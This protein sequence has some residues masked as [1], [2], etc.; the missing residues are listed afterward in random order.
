MCKRSL[1]TAEPIMPKEQVTQ[2]VHLGSND[3]L[4]NG[5]MCGLGLLIRTLVI[6]LLSPY[7]SPNPSTLQMNQG[8]I[9]CSSTLSPLTIHYMYIK[10]STT[11][12]NDILPSKNASFGIMHRRLK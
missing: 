2:G 7:S 1:T 11:S 9:V 5:Y 12:I 6:I 3:T 10:Y 8:N 4:R